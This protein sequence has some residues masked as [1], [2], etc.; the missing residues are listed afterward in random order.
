MSLI[1][2]STEGVQNSFRYQLKFDD[3]IVA[4]FNEV[5]NV[6]SAPIKQ[7]STG[8]GQFKYSAIEFSNGISYNPEFTEWCANIWELEAEDNTQPKPLVDDLKNL[9]LIVYDEEG[10]AVRKYSILKAWPTHCNFKSSENEAL[11]ISLTLQ[12]HGILKIK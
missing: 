8:V 4:G 12:I 5:E 2:Q 10:Q 3:S 9:T 1:Q 11:I 6:D 7:Q